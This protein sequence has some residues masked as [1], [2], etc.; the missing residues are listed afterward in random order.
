M[1]AEPTYYSLMPIRI[2]LSSTV[3]PGYTIPYFNTLLN[4]PNAHALP[5]GNLGFVYPPLFFDDLAP[6]VH[7]TMETAPTFADL[8]PPGW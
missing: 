3:F 4:N 7:S 6:L 1:S 2:G 5:V 8:V